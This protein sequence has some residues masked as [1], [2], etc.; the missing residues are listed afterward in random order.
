MWSGRAAAL[1][2]ARCDHRRV[3]RPRPMAGKLRARSHARRARDTRRPSRSS[4]RT[5]KWATGPGSCV[6][7]GCVPCSKSRS[8]RQPDPD[9]RL[10]VWSGFAEARYRPVPRWQVGVRIDRLTFGD[11]PGAL[12]AATGTSWDADVSRV[13]AVLGFRATSARRATGRMAA[14]LARRWP[15][16]RTRPAGVRGARL[17]LKHATPGSPAP[18]ATA[19]SGALR[20]SPGAGPHGRYDSRPRRRAERAGRAVHGRRSPNRRRRHIRS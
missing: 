16:S 4:P 2:G 13:E 1:L 5:S 12:P 17:V 7:S 6:G 15:R 9:A 19:D 18:H 8:S 11:A 10:H 14:Q 20:G 3:R